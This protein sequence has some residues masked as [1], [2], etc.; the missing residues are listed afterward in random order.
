VGSSRSE[1]PE[2]SKVNTV[3]VVPLGGLMVNDAEGEVL[4]LLVVVNERTSP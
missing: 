1:L 4:E 3:E 2:A